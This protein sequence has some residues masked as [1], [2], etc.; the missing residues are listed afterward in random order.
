MADFKASADIGT[1]PEAQLE[2]QRWWADGDTKEE[3]CIYKYSDEIHIHCFTQE[4]TNCTKLL[5]WGLNLSCVVNGFLI[6]VP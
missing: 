4:P 1:D 6:W 3:C 5:I 2:N